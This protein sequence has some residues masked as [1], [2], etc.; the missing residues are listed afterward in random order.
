MKVLCSRTMCP[1]IWTSDSRTP[2]QIFMTTKEN[3][4]GSVFLKLS[5]H[6]TV[7]TGDANDVVFTCCLVVAFCFVKAQKRFF[8]KMTSLAN[9]NE[10]SKINT[11]T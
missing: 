4:S 10:Q 2:K 1:T 3:Q 5:P 8:F 7:S 11:Q 9:Y 6:P